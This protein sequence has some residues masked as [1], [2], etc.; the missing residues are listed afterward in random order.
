ME[1]GI[2]AASQRGGTLL[3]LIWRKPGLAQQPPLLSKIPSAA[4]HSWLW[5]SDGAGGG[6]GRGV[7]TEGCSIKESAMGEPICNQAVVKRK[8]CSFRARRLC[9]GLPPDC[10]QVRGGNLDESFHFSGHQFSYPNK[11][12]KDTLCTPPLLETIAMSNRIIRM[13]LPMSWS[14][15]TQQVRDRARLQT[16]LSKWRCI[17][18]P[19]LTAE[20]CSAASRGTGAGKA[21]KG[22]WGWPHA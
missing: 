13:L 12:D 10:L 9:R 3:F 22:G 17:I 6:A 15:D 19:Q 7:D 14:K 5:G 8:R 18:Q 4:W 1:W 16:L 20:M 11:G 2:Q 21:Y